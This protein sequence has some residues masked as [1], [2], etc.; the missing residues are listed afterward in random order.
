MPRLPFL[1]LLAS[2]SLP[3]FVHAQ[4]SQ[5][6]QNMGASE[7]VTTTESIDQSQPLADQLAQSEQQRMQLLER[8]NSQRDTQQAD[9]IA[10]LNQ[11]IAKLNSELQQRQNKTPF[12]SF[13]T[14]EQSWYVLGAIT[15]LIAGFFG[16]LLRGGR[17]RRR[18]WVN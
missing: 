11:Q 15:V 8:L 1:L 13:L 18:E 2:L 10:R 6:Q 7:T 9:E 17:G 4:E 5:E 16:S 12:I 14:E 3:A